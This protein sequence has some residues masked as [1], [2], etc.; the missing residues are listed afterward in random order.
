MKT[1]K[2][3]GGKPTKLR[4]HKPDDERHGMMA[5]NIKEPEYELSWEDNQRYRDLMKYCTAYSNNEIIIH[6]EMELLEKY[7]RELRKTIVSYV[8]PMKPVINISK[9]RQILESLK[10]TAKR[11]IDETEGKGIR[12]LN[13]LFYDMYEIIDIEKQGESI[14]K[15][16][17]CFFTFGSKVKSS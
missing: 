10:V 13:Y 7:Y 16:F 5:D 4:L 17:S 14:I 2:K 12:T 15:F 3:R 11:I 6:T 9:S 1:K 8:N